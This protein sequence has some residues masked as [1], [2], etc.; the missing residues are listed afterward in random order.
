MSKH[1]HHNGVIDKIDN[2][3]AYVRIIQQSACAGCHARSM[4]SASESKEKIIE[5][6][7]HSGKYTINEEVLICG[8]N[9]LGLQAVFLAFVIPVI[10]LVLVLV[11]ASATNS[12]E[13]ISAL[14]GLIC[15]VLYYIIL[16][17][18]RDKLK[19]KFV[20]TLKKLN[21]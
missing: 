8:Q 20:F 15:L 11:I 7:D 3:I 1:I 2:G 10:I 4:C 16:Y 6:V 12:S 17:L 19:R 13:A 18:F 14:S 21:S 5:V 9:S